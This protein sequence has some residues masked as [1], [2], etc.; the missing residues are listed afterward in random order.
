MI[1]N[2]K[3]IVN[4]IFYLLK[5]NKVDEFVDIIYQ[6]YIDNN[7]LN[8]GV[9]KFYWAIPSKI[10]THIMFLIPKKQ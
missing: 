8:K 5:T 10:L 4:E 3:N 9:N 6:Y 2:L 1:S 7:I